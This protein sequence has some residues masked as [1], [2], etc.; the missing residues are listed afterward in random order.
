MK[1]TPFN[2]TVHDHSKD[3][4]GA[5]LTPD[6]LEDLIAAALGDAGF[7]YAFVEVHL[8]EQT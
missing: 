6:R 1:T 7:D 2:V 4:D 8:R 5:A 3:D